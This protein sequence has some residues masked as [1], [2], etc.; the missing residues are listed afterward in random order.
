[1]S[2][3]VI[4]ILC[5]MDAG[6]VEFQ[7]AL[8]CAP[9]ITGLKISNL[10]LVQKRQVYKL[11]KVLGQDR[12]SRYVLYTDKEKSVIL[13]Y[14]RRELC[15]YLLRN[16][17][18]E[19]MLRCG[20]REKNPES[21]LWTFA[22]R[23]R[24]YRIGK[25]GFPHELGILLGIPLEDVEGFIQNEGKNCL[26]SGYWKVYRDVTAKK[27]LFRMYELARELMIE[28]V[29]NGVGMEEII[30]TYRLNRSISGSGIAW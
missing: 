19:F 28:L 14:Q 5:A 22:C 2:R 4:R 26:Y 9:L 12:F 8:Q 24:R 20:Y 3:D 7:L 17:I 29:C 25:Q 18:W 13:L 16:D 6:N 21:I 10:L 15:R 1:M 11:W 30:D 27:N 23:Y